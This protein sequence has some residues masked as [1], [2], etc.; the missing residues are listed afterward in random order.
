MR[1]HI[2]KSNGHACEKNSERDNHII[3][4]ESLLFLVETN[5]FPNM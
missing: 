5:N 2:T 3:I 4:W 1:V